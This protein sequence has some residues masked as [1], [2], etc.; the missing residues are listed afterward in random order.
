MGSIP[1]LF[2]LLHQ[3]L[4]WTRSKREVSTV[5]AHSDELNMH[6]PDHENEPTSSRDALDLLLSGSQDHAHSRGWQVLPLNTHTAAH[7]SP[8]TAR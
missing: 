6:E 7:K 2:Y 8:L 5:K 4:Y 3:S 1:T